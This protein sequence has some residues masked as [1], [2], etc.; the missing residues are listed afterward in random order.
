MAKD[1]KPEES[2]DA[3]DDGT[4]SEDTGGEVLDEPKAPATESPAVLDHRAK[5]KR[6]D[7]TRGF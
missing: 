2:V 1:K 6:M 7:E 3:V 5:L 4:P